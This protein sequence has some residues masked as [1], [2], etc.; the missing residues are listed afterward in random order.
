[1]FCGVVAAVVVAVDVGRGVRG[2]LVQLMVALVLALA[3]DRVV[4][5]VQRRLRLGRGAAVALVVGVSATLTAGALVL[6]ARAMVRQ[7]TQGS[8]DAGAVA[9]DLEETPVVGELV[10]RYE[11]SERV[12]SWLGGLPERLDSGLGAIGGTVRLLLDAVTG[13]ALTFLL[14][15]L[16]LLEGPQ[17]VAAAHRRLPPA[18]RELASRLGSSLYVAIGRYA[19]GSLALAMLAGSAALAIG[20]ALGV[21]L[22]VAAGLWALLWNFVP[23]LG[24]I[25]G[26]GALVVLAATRSVGTA[27]VALAL[28]LAYS[29]LENRLVQ[30]V[31]IGRAVQLSPMTTMLGALGGAAVAGLVG[32]VLAVPLAAAAKVAYTELRPRSVPLP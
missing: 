3:L 9:A 5:A 32:A 25:V 16:L 21:P 31:V 17:L 24:G 11:V 10:R 14:V 28:W 23:Q 19:V 7:A 22:A 26:G 30:P 1:M 13:A 6:L 27:L 12:Q 2:T 18:R 8:L 29:Q 15:V 4:G 20:L